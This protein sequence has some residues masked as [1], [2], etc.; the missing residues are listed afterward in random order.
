MYIMNRPFV[1]NLIERLSR[2]AEESLWMRLFMH[3]LTFIQR[4]PA[5]GHLEV[6]QLVES[7]R[8]WSVT[9]TDQ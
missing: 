9:A 2:L 7:K 5:E 3:G 4:W 8:L 1:N 6:K